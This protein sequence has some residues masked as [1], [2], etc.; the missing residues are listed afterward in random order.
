[1]LFMIAAFGTSHLTS[2]SYCAGHAHC[3]VT[4]LPGYEP[5]GMKVRGLDSE[6]SAL[7]AVDPSLSLHKPWFEQLSPPPA[8]GP[9]VYTWGDVPPPQVPEQ[10]TS[11]DTIKK[12]SSTDRG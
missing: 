6:V 2:V 8:L 9:S 4:G 11:S 10:P 5:E 12:N 7:S 1:M 3:P